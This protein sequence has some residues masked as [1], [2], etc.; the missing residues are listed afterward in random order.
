MMSMMNDGVYVLLQHQA[1]ALAPPASSLCR[2]AF[3]RWMG[4]EGGF[5]EPFRTKKGREGL[6]ALLISGAELASRGKGAPKR[7]RPDFELK[8]RGFLI[9]GARPGGAATA[10]RAR[11]LGP[12]RVLFFFC[13]CFF[14]L[15][16][17][18][19]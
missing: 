4:R 13:V 14:F 3:W 17:H 1:L 8:G 10:R 18:V 12:N 11:A 9:I 15:A 6:P 19:M 16:L 5:L 2:H 7:G